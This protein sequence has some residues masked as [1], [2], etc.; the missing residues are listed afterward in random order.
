MAFK[1]GFEAAEGADIYINI[2]L[3]I[4]AYVRIS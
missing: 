1:T 3:E 2:N 4:R